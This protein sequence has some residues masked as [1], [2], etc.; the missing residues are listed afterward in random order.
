MIG[1]SLSHYA[2]TEKLGQNG[3]GE[4]CPSRKFDPGGNQHGQ[5]RL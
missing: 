3:M 1:T 4:G 5:A 2:I